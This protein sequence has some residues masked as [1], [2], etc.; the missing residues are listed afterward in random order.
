MREGKRCSG[1]GVGEDKVTA[2]RGRSEE[3]EP[4][5]AE[6]QEQGEEGEGDAFAFGGSER[7]G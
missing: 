3:G 7:H 1:A 5:K 6:D 4:E 2:R